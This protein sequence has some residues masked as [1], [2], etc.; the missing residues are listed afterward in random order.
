MFPRHSTDIETAE[1]HSACCLPATEG[2]QHH[3]SLALL[4]P[5]SGLER[6][7]IPQQE[8]L[9]DET[10]VMEEMVAEVPMGANPIQVKIGEFDE[11]A[12]EAKEEVVV[13]NP[14]QNH[15]C[16]LGKVCEL[17][18]NNTPMCMC[19][20]HAPICEFEKVC[21]NDKT[22]DYSCYFFAIKCTLKG[23]KKGHKL[24]LD[25]IRSLPG[26]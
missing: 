12:E 24:H 7:G 22:F 21:S 23:T 5:F 15:H 6:L 14:C 4:S 19:Q 25:Y 10:E 3:E 11:D 20:E 8:A 17:D 9:P 16:T 2:S 1:V 13:E 26:F 18:E